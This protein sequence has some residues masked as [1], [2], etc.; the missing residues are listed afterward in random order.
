M[1][2]VSPGETARGSSLKEG[3]RMP[4]SMPPWARAGAAPK[5]RSANIRA[6]TSEPI[7]RPLSI[8]SPLSLLRI[9]HLTDSARMGHRYRSPIVVS[10]V[11]VRGIKNRSATLDVV[12]Q[13]AMGEMSAKMESGPAVSPGIE[14]TL[15]ML[16]QQPPRAEILEPFVQAARDVLAEELGVEVTARKLALASGAAT[17]LDVT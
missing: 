6:S 11:A 15:A 17:T 7:S 8:P 4:T 3:V 2:N 13:Q 10:S 14:R 5:V 1:A 16:A 12:V 9:G